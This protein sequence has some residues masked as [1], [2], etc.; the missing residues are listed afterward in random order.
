[1]PLS[2]EVI[3]AESGRFAYRD[4]RYDALVDEFDGLM[5]ARDAGELTVAGYLATLN[6]LLVVAPDFV[7]VHAHIALLWHDQHKPKKA[8]AAALLGLSAANRVIPEDFNGRIEWGILD[9]R[10]YL[11][12][13]NLVLQSYARL[14]RH[15]DAV[16]TIDLMLTRN[17]DDNQGV[18]FLLGSEALRAGDY[19]RARSVF[20]AEA[21]A[22][23][24]YFYELALIHTLREDWVSA[25]TALRRGLAA[26]PYIAEIISGNLIPAPL[27]IWHGTDFAEPEVA[28]EYMQMYGPYSHN[29]PPNVPFT[30]W[31]FNHSKVL[32]ER[33]AIME[34]REALLWERDMAARTKL[35]N[36][37]YR[38]IDKIDDKL[39]AAIV[40][41]HT[42]RYGKARWPWVQETHD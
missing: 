8:L 39:S 27:P 25:A 36:S 1:M 23:P 17:P 2:F 4:E 40:T 37:L 41:R 16:T 18:R 20:E 34:C 35:L 15:K 22:Y 13:M 10:P 32:A 21:H 7:D 12:A 11:R 31:L 3:H 5:D 38:L 14:R 33:A 29:M 9:N 24:P 26:N 19:D 30:R 42:D 6:R 28:R